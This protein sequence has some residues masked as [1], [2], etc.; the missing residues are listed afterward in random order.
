MKEWY[1]SWFDSPYY[2]I[3]Y[4]NRD[5]NEADIFLEKLAAFLALPEGSRVLDI[6]CGKGRHS[7]FLNNKGF[8]VTGIDLSHQSI[9]YCLQF[10]NAKLTFYVHD[11]RE[12]FRTNVYDLAV[13][14]FT[15]FGYFSNENDNL[16][17]LRSAA[18]AL[19]P[20][21]LFVL[22]FFNP[23]KVKMGEM[24][25]IE[26]T[27]DAVNFKI[28]KKVENGF[29]VKDIRF[30][31]ITTDYHFTE[32]VQLIPQQKFIQYFQKAGLRILHT[33]GNYA[34][35][36]YDPIQSDRLIFVAQKAE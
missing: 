36:P 14:L 24:H 9:N 8:E 1:Q 35:Q 31:D 6:A 28:N 11:M 21:G 27:V 15:S 3:L 30:S 5:Q 12:L 13:N 25:V 22:D 29:I 10:E 7:L 18:L 17:A 23:E 26:K 4:K 19:K 32:T 20:G 33:F 2:H 16:L 34:L